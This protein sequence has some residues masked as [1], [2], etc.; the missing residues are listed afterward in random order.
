[1]AQVKLL[2]ISS[3]GVPLEFTSSADDITLLSFSVNG[4]GP[5]LSGT[6]LD[7]NNQDLSDVSDIDFNDPAVSTIEQTAGA[8]IV[9]NIMAKER[10]NVM[11][12][13][14]AVLFPSVTDTAAQL[15]SFKLPHIA[16]APTAT[17]SFSSDAGY[18]VYDTTNNYLYVWDGAAWQNQTLADQAQRVVN[19]YTADEALA[20]RDTLYIS[21][22][23]NVSK[24]D[25]SGSGAPSRIIGFARAAA[26]DT[27][28]VEVQSEGVLTG[29]TGLTAGARY[30]GDPA[31]PGLITST[32]P[33]G[34]GNTIVQVGY[35]KSTT[36][37][38][39][40]IEQMG[41]RS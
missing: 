25:V 1:M 4:G 18:T 27:A 11:T 21:A 34:A 9:D 20:A 30:Y 36:A 14:G 38:H 6:G 41:R 16:G 10:N 22:A 31:T 35:A 32:I 17:P 7:L 5:V 40:H 2:K 26:S 29:F 33:V 12:S 3:D 24:A 8:L 13:A 15:D 19:S 23:D 39:I 28:S 37:L